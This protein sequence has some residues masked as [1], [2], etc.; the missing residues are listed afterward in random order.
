MYSYVVF[1]TLVFGDF[2]I[3]EEEATLLHKSSVNENN[4]FYN[5]FYCVTYVYSTKE[6][7]TLTLSRYRDEVKT[8]ILCQVD[9]TQQSQLGVT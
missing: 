3:S 7:W 6:A 1:K 5:F 8:L 9:L 2:K 4:L